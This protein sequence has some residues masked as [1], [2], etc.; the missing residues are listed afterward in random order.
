[1]KAWLQSKELWQPILHHWFIKVIPTLLILVVVWYLGLTA[2]I[3]T[4]IVG[5]FS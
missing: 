5:I 1:M 3:V 4:A 2:D